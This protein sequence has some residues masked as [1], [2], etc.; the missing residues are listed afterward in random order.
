MHKLIALTIGWLVALR[1][2]LRKRDS[3]GLSQ[4]TKNAILLV[5]AVVIAGIVIAA[6][7]GFVQNEMANV[8]A[9]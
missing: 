7:T 8:K 6:I 3:R 2:P 4:S 1:A 5:G 9:P